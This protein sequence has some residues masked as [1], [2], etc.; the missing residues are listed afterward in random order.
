MIIIKLIKKLDKL[1]FFGLL[2]FI[3]NKLKNYSTVAYLKNFNYDYTSYYNVKKTLL[4]DLCDKYGCDKGYNKIKNRKF[5]ND[6]HPHNYTDYYSSLFD[7][8]K[9]TVKKVFECG[10]G[11]NKI[12]FPSSMGKD[13]IPGASLKIWR[14]YFQNAQIYG[15]DLDSD[16]LF[17]SEKIKTFYVNQLEKSSIEKMWEQI[18]SNN[19]D[20]I[21]DDGL[22]TLEA[23]ITL[24]EN[25]FKYLKKGGIYIIEDVDPSYLTD[26]SKHLESK[27]NV[28]IILLKSKNKK[29]LKDNNL[30]VIRN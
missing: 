4:S 6:W 11:S 16:I 19:F 30:I 8:N 3:H 10:I 24:F 26:L 27:N 14:D 13:Y 20:L 17:Q 28:E 1:F 23:G 25:S 22:H 15:A 5:F 7:H 21:I 9:E 12:N 29:L 2:K 18:N